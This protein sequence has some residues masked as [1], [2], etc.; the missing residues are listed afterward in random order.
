VN[1]EKVN[2]VLMEILERKYDV[3]INKK[4]EPLNISQ[5]LKE[6]CH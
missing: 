1:Y 2:K 6:E 4:I 5:N 3:K